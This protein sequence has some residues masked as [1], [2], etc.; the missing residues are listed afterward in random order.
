MP[1]VTV[2]TNIAD[3]KVPRDFNEK[4]TNVLAESMNKPVNRIAVLLQAGA[5]F[6][7][8]ATF[9]PAILVSVSF[10]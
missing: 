5:R 9:D 2:T 3:D 10:L 4:L 1:M 6:T 8:G 7:H